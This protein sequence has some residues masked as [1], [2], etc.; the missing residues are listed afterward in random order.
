MYG[1]QA[2]NRATGAAAL[3]RFETA[4][5]AVAGRSEQPIEAQLRRLHQGIA[6]ANAIAEQLAVRV[7]P[8]SAV[9]P[10]G[11]EKER[12]GTVPAS[13][14]VARQLFEANEQ[15]RRLIERLHRTIGALEV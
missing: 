12:Q 3:A 10:E 2:A 8:V 4:T 7:R 14:E 11:V 1:E 9:M 6:E 5:E 15:M 13:S